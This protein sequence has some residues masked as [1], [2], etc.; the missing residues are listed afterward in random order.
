YRAKVDELAAQ[1][2]NIIEEEREE[3][4]FRDAEMQMTKASNLIEHK[5]EIQSRP[6]RTWFQSEKSRKES[7][8]ASA[9]S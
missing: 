8:R 5:D 7:K 6:R 2:K 9:S 1:V 4:M 3:K